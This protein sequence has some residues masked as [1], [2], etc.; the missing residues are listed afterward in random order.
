M[1][2]AIFYNHYKHLSKKM[3]ALLCLC[4]AAISTPNRLLLAY[5]EPGGDILVALI[6]S[7]LD[8]GIQDLW[9]LERAQAYDKYERWWKTRQQRLCMANIV[10]RS[11]LKHSNKTHRLSQTPI[12]NVLKFE[13][14]ISVAAV[15]WILMFCL[16]SLSQMSVSERPT[17]ASSQN[18]KWT[19]LIW[20]ISFSTSTNRGL[21]NWPLIHPFTHGRWQNGHAR[22][23][24]AHWKQ[25]RVR[26][27]VRR[28]SDI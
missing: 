7:S 11:P 20:Y 22:R 25:V 17:I 12:Q 23:R 21:Y 14:A 2:K 10:L 18:G 15:H 4:T 28:H 8:S 3:C 1:T 5:Q 26:C 9:Q 13:F 19:A 27:L 16:Y 6:R 24:P